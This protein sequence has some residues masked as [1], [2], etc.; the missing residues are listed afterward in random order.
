MDG[1]NTMDLNGGGL[2]DMTPVFS[3]DT[4]PK[5]PEV[6]KQYEVPPPINAPEKNIS[7]SKMD[8]TP[9]ND[10][11]GPPGGDMSGQD[12]RFMMEQAPM[13]VQQAQHVPNKTSSSSKNPMNLTDEQMEALLAGVAAVIAFSSGVQGKLATTIPQF[14]SEA[15]ERSNIGL[16]VTA[17]LAALVFYFAKRFVIKD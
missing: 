6:K 12:P 10:I 11:M 7:K 4:P 16:L 5:E 8:S 1:V 3:F 13:Y 2:S 17:L 14:L 9:I 15:G